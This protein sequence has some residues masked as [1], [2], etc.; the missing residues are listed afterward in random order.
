MLKMW[1]VIVLLVVV[2][3]SGRFLHFDSDQTV[4]LIRHAEKLD[5]GPDLSPAGYEVKI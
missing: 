4:I 1:L 3:V 5:S 2:S